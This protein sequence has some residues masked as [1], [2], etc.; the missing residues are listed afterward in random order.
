MH[1]IGTAGHVDHGKSA[2]VRAL[3]GT[4]PDRWLQEQLRGMTLD[5]GF[6][7]LRFD[8]GLEAGIIDVPGHERFL[9]NMLAGAAGME[10]LL[11]VVAANEGARP[12]TLEHLA[13]LR[14]LHV[15]R[16]IVVLSKSD[17][18][19]REE[20]DFATELIREELRGTIAQG[21]PLIAVSSH[22]G[23]NMDRLRECIQEELQ[24]LEE[25]PKDALPYL[26]IDRVFALPGHGTIVTGTLM[27]GV[28]KIGDQLT[29]S[30]SGRSVRVR[31][32]QV[33]N[34]KQ[35][36]VSGGSRVAV[37]IPGIAV[38]D[39]SR[40]ETLASPEF[41]TEAR[42]RVNFMPLPDALPLFRRRNPMRMHLASAEIL[43]T[44][45]FDEVPGSIKTYPATV[46][47]RRPAVAFTGEHFVVRRLSPK[48]LLGGGVIAAAEAFPAAETGTQGDRHAFRVAA[49]LRES[50]Y[51]P[52]T[53][54][55]IAALANLREPVVLEALEELRNAGEV[56]ALSKPVAYLHQDALSEVLNRTIDALRAQ[57][58]ASPWI[59]GMTSLALARTL[60]FDESLLVRILAVLSEDGHLMYR[61]GYYA[62]L[63]YA[64]RLSDDQTR[65]FEQHIPADRSASFLPASLPEVVSR[66]KAARITGLSQAFDT[67]IANGILVKIGDALYTGSQLSQIKAKLQSLMRKEGD[68]TMATFRDLIGT[69]RKYAVPLLEWFDA[70]GV[71]VRTG[72]VRRLRAYGLSAQ[73]EN[74]FRVL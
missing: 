15:Q 39:I 17:L 59:L 41:T 49:L 6:A 1:I 3:T 32:L 25:R 31:G 10:L 46:H 23:A 19:A 29:L 43:G 9:H 67:L 71:T 28:I 30:P 58:T 24:H 44:L 62:T 16:V 34:Q 8:N 68:L 13:I 4:N 18:L 72:D 22:S 27:Q 47:L 21:A 36:R 12:Q 40:G 66:I 38:H 56:A 65:F 54:E 64:P 73:P 20:L 2:L 63:T 11:L 52:L 35:D 51:A 37:N 60:K 33:F 48:T 69:S 14:Y 45:I 57:E 55:K 7:H 42:L 74:A 53:S 5:L 61:A 50:G 70:S 26:P